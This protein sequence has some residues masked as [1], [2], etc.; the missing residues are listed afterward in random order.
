MTQYNY[1][2]SDMGNF[3][4]TFTMIFDT[5]LNTFSLLIT[6]TPYFTIIPSIAIFQRLFDLM[7]KDEKLCMVMEPLKLN[8]GLVMIVCR[9]VI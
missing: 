7:N 8:L 9:C 5:H 6:L 2:V 3:Y 4:D 1:F